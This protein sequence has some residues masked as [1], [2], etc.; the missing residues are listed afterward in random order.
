[1]I[2][3]TVY[4]I[5]KIGKWRIARQQ[6]ETTSCLVLS[7]YVASLK[8][9][10]ENQPPYQ[11]NLLDI[12]AADEPLTSQILSLILQ[13]RYNG[14]FPLLE[15]FFDRFLTHIRLS[16]DDI[17][18]PGI[19][20]EAD[21]ID[22]RIFDDSYAVIIEN[23]I[24][25]A[26]YQ[27]NQL[28]RYIE[29]V[30]NKWGYPYERIFIVL[31][32][33]FADDKYVEGIRKSAWC[34]PPDWE[35][36]NG[37]RHCR[38][39]DQYQCWCDEEERNYT[40]EELCHCSRCKRDFR[41]LFIGRTA[42]VGSEFADWLQDVAE[43]L[44]AKEIILK[45]ALY[46]FSDYAKGLYQTKTNNN[47]IMQLKNQIENTVLAG[48]DSNCEKWK[49]LNEHLDNLPDIVNAMKDMRLELSKDL[50]DEWYHELKD[51]WPDL[52]REVHKSFG[53]L[54]RGVWVGCWCGSDN[55]GT[56]YWGFYSEGDCTEEQKAMVAAIL[57]E[58]DIPSPQ[59]SQNFIAWNST[60]HG[61]DR[62]RAFYRAA[63]KLLLSFGC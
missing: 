1:M 33:R 6:E 38:S 3:E 51:E 36:S 32:P 15:S 14:H 53:M 54:I 41:D 39:I 50:V 57:A 17:R 58:C 27:R 7:D 34:C 16:A 4:G 35:S 2:E 8:A 48:I 62:C 29:R 18:H 47:I 9:K 10:P 20:A 23:K 43:S 44:P 5:L 45:S 26:V 42:V 30:H 56:P 28:G 59:R 22:I 31:L 13:Y 25:N 12:G 21:H 46:Q 49:L 60:L 40:K 55:G 19:V 37:E 52:R 63:Q 24:R 61:A 11:L